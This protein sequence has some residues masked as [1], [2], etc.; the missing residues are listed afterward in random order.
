METIL[1][2]EPE[3][4]L[5]AQGRRIA[6]M[7]RSQGVL[8]GTCIWFDRRGQVLAIGW[9]LQGVPF[10]GTVLNWSRFMPPPDKTGPFDWEYYARDWITPFEASFDSA[11]PDY[12]AVV[13]TYLR[14]RKL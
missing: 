7:T 4:I 6:E 5:D 14:G 9:F 11:P 1:F 2:D 10:A 8:D 12:G 13:E 3:T